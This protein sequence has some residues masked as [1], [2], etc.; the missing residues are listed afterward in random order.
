MPKLFDTLAQCFNADELKQSGLSEGFGDIEFFNYHN[1]RIRRK[2][3]DLKFIVFLAPENNPE[4]DNDQK[5]KQKIPAQRAA[6]SEKLLVSGNK[7]NPE[8]FE[9]H[10]FS[11]L[12]SHFSLQSLSP[13]PVIRI[14]TSSK[15]G[16]RNPSVTQSEQ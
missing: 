7:H 15:L 14:N 4:S 2:Y 9:T 8:S 13:R 12:I 11:L 1:F 3:A 6:V 10:N 5:R 16:A